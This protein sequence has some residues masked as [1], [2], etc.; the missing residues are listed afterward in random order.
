MQRLYARKN[1]L[2]N[3][4]I[5]QSKNPNLTALEEGLRKAVLSE[6]KAKTAFERL[7]EHGYETNHLIIHLTLW[8][9]SPEVLFSQ[10]D[11][12]ELPGRDGKKRLQRF[13]LK[14]HVIAD[15]LAGENLCKELL[16]PKFLERNQIVAQNGGLEM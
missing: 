11:R 8:A 10:S 5:A 1:M 2:R 6:N 16:E 13:S 4:K 15:E 12:A 7:V 14:L 9:R 3:E